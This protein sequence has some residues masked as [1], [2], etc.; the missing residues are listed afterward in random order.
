MTKKELMEYINSEGIDLGRYGIVIGS[1]SNTPY[2]MGCYEEE[3]T[4][5]I[6]DV[7]ER[8]DF[9]IVKSG[10]E[11]EVINYFY[12]LIRGKIRTMENN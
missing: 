3:G 5:Y 12:L 2:T 4:W 6:Y 11:E 10:K 1:K 9:G 8:Q 7:G